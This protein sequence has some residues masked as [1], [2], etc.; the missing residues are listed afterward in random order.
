MNSA[1]CA[2]LNLPGA[3]LAIVLALALQ[4]TATTATAQLPELGLPSALSGMPTT[5]KF[6]AGATSDDG[7]SYKANFSADSLLDVLTEIRVEPDH[8]NTIGSLYL[9]LL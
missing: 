8:V 4:L 2:Q 6:Y 1:A 7:A 9:V 3:Y 5:A